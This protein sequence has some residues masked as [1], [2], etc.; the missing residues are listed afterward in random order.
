M[1]TVLRMHTQGI[2][3]LCAILFFFSRFSPA[4]S[5]VICTKPSLLSVPLVS[6]PWHMSIFINGIDLALKFRWIDFMGANPYMPHACSWTHS[7][8]LFGVSVSMRV[9]FFF[10]L[11]SSV[12]LQHEVCV[13]SCW[14]E[15]MTAKSYQLCKSIHTTV[16]LTMYLDRNLLAVLCT[17]YVRLLTQVDS[18]CT[19]ISPFSFTW[20]LSSSIFSFNQILK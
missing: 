2:I 18:T 7:A 19:Y 8:G 13:A 5:Y 4:N 17:Y 6:P 10:L 15:W 1:K 12:Q 20:S 14:K 3:W 9:F 16:V 11:L